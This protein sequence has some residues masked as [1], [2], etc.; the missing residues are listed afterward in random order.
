M[1]ANLIKTNLGSAAATGVQILTGCGGNGAAG[2]QIE[3][4]NCADILTMGVVT[5]TRARCGRR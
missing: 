1:K 2:V 3:R 4:A 5:T